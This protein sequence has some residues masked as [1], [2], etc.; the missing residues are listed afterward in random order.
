[1]DIQK[2]MLNVLQKSITEFEVYNIA[3]IPG[4]LTFPDLPDEQVGAILV[5]DLH[6]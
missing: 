4:S 6:R 3:P 1:M 2:E 5:F